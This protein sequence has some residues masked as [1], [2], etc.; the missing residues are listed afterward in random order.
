M[1]DSF[2]SYVKP[3]RVLSAQNAVSGPETF[4]STPVRN[5]LH[6]EVICYRITSDLLCYLQC[7]E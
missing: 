6:G 1:C 4:Q 3:G 7:S 2:F 5:S